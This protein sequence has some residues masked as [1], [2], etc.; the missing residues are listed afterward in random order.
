MVGLFGFGG[1]GADLVRETVR[2]RGPG[3]TDVGRDGGAEPAGSILS[4]DRLRRVDTRRPRFEAKL[5]ADVEVGV[6]SSLTM[7]TVGVAT[8]CTLLVWVLIVGSDIG[9]GFGESGRDGRA[10]C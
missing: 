9:G 10:C 8:G 4:L 5:V 2:I 6:E 1:F 7:L 3:P